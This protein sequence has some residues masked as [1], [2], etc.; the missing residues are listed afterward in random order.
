[1]VKNIKNNGRKKVLLLGIT[2]SGKSA[3]GNRI[4]GLHFKSATGFSVSGGYRGCTRE[5]RF[6]NTNFN[7]DLEKPINLI[8]TIGF[9]DPDQN[10]DDSEDEGGDIQ[11]GIMSELIIRLRDDCDHVNLFLIVVRGEELS[12]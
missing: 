11:N 6:K 7:G 12:S 2:G 1:M 10:V 5:T 4:G 9:E 3:M 8:D